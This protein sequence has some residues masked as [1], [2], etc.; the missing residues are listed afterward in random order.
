MPSE[1]QEISET[2]FGIAFWRKLARMMGGNVTVR[3][4]PGAKD[5]FHAAPDRLC[6]CLNLV[7]SEPMRSTAS[8]S[9]ERKRL[10]WPWWQTGAIRKSGL[11]TLHTNIWPC[12]RWS[13]PEIR[14]GREQAD[15]RKHLGE[16]RL[17]LGPDKWSEGVDY[18]YDDDR[19]SAPIW[20]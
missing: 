4:E 2:G 3:S 10:L 12:R 17:V 18:K 6:S 14:D 19:H 1:C 7:Q 8:G 20:L 13:P 9:P 15:R 5:R 11:P 16:Q